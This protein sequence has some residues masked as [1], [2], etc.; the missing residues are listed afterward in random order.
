[1]KIKYKLFR[2][3]FPLV[4]T[5][6]GN[7]SNMERVYC[8]NCGEKDCFRETTKEDHMKFEED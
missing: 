6:C 1:M 4:C 2:Q 5:K 3:T 8:E 7:L